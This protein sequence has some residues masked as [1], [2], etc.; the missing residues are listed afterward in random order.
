ML[1]AT[2]LFA[3]VAGALSWHARPLARNS[4]AHAEL[5]RFD[6]RAEAEV[7]R[8]LYRMVQ[9]AIDQRP[10]LDGTPEQRQVGDLSITVRI[11]DERGKIDLNA[12]KPEAF[13]ALLLW[14]GA[15]DEQAA[16][17]L[18]RLI[19]FR[20]TD[21]TVRFNGAE[22]ADYRDQDWLFQAK[23]GPFESLSELRQI[24]PT[25]GLNLVQLEDFFTVE[26]RSGRVDPF[27]A[28]PELKQALDLQLPSVRTN[29]AAAL[30]GI[31]TIEVTVERGSGPAVRQRSVVQL[32]KSRGRPYRI[33]NRGSGLTV[34]PAPQAV[35]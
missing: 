18:D 29:P 28:S 3:V 14:S 13:T 27:T 16:E 32:S 8:T 31:Y 26:S 9:P 20:D 34:R 2:V 7:H 5:A 23:D 19:D 10:L 17:F 15:T 22:D 30:V 35:D 21:Q 4:Q 24:L 1:W 6:L 11:W 33:V 12:G 25:P